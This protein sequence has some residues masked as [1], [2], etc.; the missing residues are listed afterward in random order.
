[1][2]APNILSIEQ[3]KE[4]T[5][6]LRQ[7]KKTIVLTNGCF[8]IIHAGHVSS[9]TYAKTQGD[10]LIVAVN[11]DSSVSRLKGASRPILPLN[12]RVQVLCALRSV[13][14]VTVFSQDNAADI[15][16]ALRPDVYVKG[17]EYDL[18]R[19]PEGMEVLKYGG[20][21]ISAPQFPGISTTAIIERICSNGGNKK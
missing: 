7:E 20:K 1:M 9:L 21:A 8:D 18:S 2:S 10:I 6:K 4:I 19:T 17:E 12:M 16:K 3:L 13:D 11:D 5:Q 15:I 14:F